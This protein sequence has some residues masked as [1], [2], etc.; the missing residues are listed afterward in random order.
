LHR[1][2]NLLLFDRIG[3]VQGFLVEFLLLRILVLITWPR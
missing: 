3:L 2:G 1:L